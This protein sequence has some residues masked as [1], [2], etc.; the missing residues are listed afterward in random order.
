[1]IY[2]IIDCYYYYIIFIL[3]ISYILLLLLLYYCWF[4]IKYVLIAKSWISS[5]NIGKISFNGLK[6]TVNLNNKLLILLSAWIRYF[7][8]NIALR[9]PSRTLIVLL[10][11]KRRFSFYLL[12]NRQRRL[13]T[14][15]FIEIFIVGSNPHLQ[16]LLSNYIRLFGCRFASK[17]HS[18][19]PIRLVIKSLFSRL[20]HDSKATINVLQ[21]IRRTPW[22]ENMFQIRILPVMLAQTTQPQ[23]TTM[24]SRTLM[25]F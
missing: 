2:W 12:E 14:V 21:C 18:Q 5:L 23:A 11:W 4:I 25:I 10:T 19:T 7:G 15:K 13:N 8:S 24:I 1:M 16:I 22:V 17:T 20:F 9:T 3:Y 6:L